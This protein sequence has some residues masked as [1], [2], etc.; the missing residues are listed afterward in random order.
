MAALL[1]DVV[2]ERG[3][4]DLICE[5]VPPVHRLLDYTDSR[6]P[7]FGVR[8]ASDSAETVSAALEATT[9][10]QAC[11]LLGRRAAPLLVRVGRTRYLLSVSGTPVAFQL[12]FRQQV[13]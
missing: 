8:F 1:A 4:S 7:Y 9:L 3:D 13:P 11:T 2:G 5:A 12:H 10:R 6:F